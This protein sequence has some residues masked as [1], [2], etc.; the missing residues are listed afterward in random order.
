MKQNLLVA[1]IA[2]LLSVNVHAQGYIYVHQKTL[3]EQA[4][5]D[6]TYNLYLG[7]TA[8]GTPVSTFKL[9]SNPAYIN[10]GDIGASHSYTGTGGDGELWCIATGVEG[11]SPNNIS[12]TIYHRASGSSQWAALTAGT[13]ITA[14][15]AIDGAYTGQCVFVSG[16]NIYFYY[17]GATTR[18]YNGG[19]ATDVAAGGGNIVAVIN[20]KVR[21][22]PLAALA[23]TAV[24]APVLTDQ[25]FTNLNLNAT[26]CD[27]SKDGSTIVYANGG[28]AYTTPFTILTII[29]PVGT[30]VY[31]AA[32][33]Y[34]ASVPDVAYDDKGF[35]YVVSRMSANGDDAVYT[36]VSG[37][38]TLEP[39]SRRVVRVTGGA[40]GQAWGV[41]NYNIT[42]SKPNTI[43]SRVTDGSTVWFDDE[44][45]RTATVGTIYTHPNTSGQTSTHGETNGDAIMI[46]VTAGT[47]YTL[48]QTLPSSNWDLGRFV[49]YTPSGNTTTT[50]VSTQ[51]A[52]FTV[53]TGSI[54]HIEFIDELLSPKSIQLTCTQQSLETFGT[55]TATY[56]DTVQG[57]GYH[58]I[59]ESYAEDGD[60]FVVKN[61]STF[62]SN[63][64]L[65]SQENDGGY[66]LIV[67]ASYAQDEFYR[68]RVTNLQPGLNYTISFYAANVNP[69]QPLLPNIKYGLQDL[70]GN[71]INLASTGDIPIT[72][73]TWEQFSLTFTATQS[74]ADLF[75][76]NNNIGGSGNDVAIDEIALNPV[77][78]AL[79]DISVYPAIAPNICI[80]TSY[81]FSNTYSPGVWSTSNSAVATITP[82][83]GV[84][85]GLTTGTAVI[86][87]RYTSAQG[88]VSTKT[89]GV[90]VSAPPTG[91]TVTDK[92]G[93][94]ICR[95]QQDSLFAVPAGGTSPYTYV[96]G[97][98]PSVNDGLSTAD[99]TKQNPQISPT[100]GASATTY[101]YTVTVTDNV[102]CTVTGS[103]N[104]AVSPHDAPTVTAT[105]GGNVC[106][107][108][109]ISLFS[110]PSGGSGTYTYAWV[111]TAAGNGLGTTNT[112]NTSATPTASGTYLYTLTL[113]DGFCSIVSATSASAA[114]KPVISAISP[115]ATGALCVG[116]SLVL[117]PTIT[118]GASAAL[119]YSWAGAYK[120]G[121]DNGP[122]VQAPTTISAVTVIPVTTNSSSGNKDTYTYTLT[123]SDG[124]SCSAS[125]AYDLVVYKGSTSSSPT[126]S[127]TSPT[128]AAAV[129]SGSTISLTATAGNTSSPTYSWS[130]P[131]GYSSSSLSPGTITPTASGIYTITVTNSGGCKAF[132]A[133]PNITVNPV[134]TAT[135]TSFAQD[136]CIG[137]TTPTLD[138]LYGSATGG[139]GSSYTYAWSNTVKPSGAG[140]I[141]YTPK[142]TGDNDTVSVN[143]ITVAGSYTFQLTASD[144]TCSGT[145]TKTITAV[146]KNGPSITAMP[147][148]GTLCIST[149]STLSSTITVGDASISSYAWSALPSTGA[150]LG[151]VNTQNISVTPT[152]V[153]SYTYVL[154][155][156]DGDG[157]ADAGQSGLQVVNAAL[158]VVPINL[159]N[160]FC[161]SGTSSNATGTLDLTAVV[162]GGSGTYS[163]YAWTAVRNVS[164]GSVTLA[165][166]T[167]NSSP[168]TVA[169]L[170]GGTI[171]TTKYT[172]TLAVTDDAGCSASGSTGSVPVN[173]KPTVSGITV[174][175]ATTKCAGKAI[176]L[177]GTF[178]GGTSPY[179]YAWTSNSSSV[180]TNASGS[181]SSSPVTT[182]STTTS[183]VSGYYPYSFTLTDANGCQGSAT[184][185]I[186]FNPKPVPSVVPQ[187]CGTTSAGVNYVQLVETNGTSLSWAWTG[188]T[189]A[190]FYTDNT[191]NPATDG[192]TSTLSNPYVTLQGIYT[193]IVT[194]ANS[195]TGTTTYTITSATCGTIVL[196]VK[197]L[198]FT[199][200]KAGNKVVLNWSTAAEISS[201]YFAVERSGDG[202]KWETIGTVKSQVNSTAIQNYSYDDNAPLNGA[203][204]YRLRQVD[205]NGHFGYS[206]VRTVQF[207]AQ[208]LVHVYPNPASDFLVLEFNNDKEERASIS[209]QTTLGSTVFMKEQTIAKGYN[210]IVLNQ[211]QPLAQGAYIITLATKTNIHRS[212]FVKGD[213]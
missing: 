61:T 49:S 66:F 57:T 210:R 90:I 21:V 35:I 200:Q 136:I 114:A 70:N 126:V 133:T 53:A 76:S 107:G 129:C 153:G 71:L 33:N 205:L 176:N 68:K 146:A 58:Y 178:S 72:Q 9:N 11:T 118:A 121:P 175:A 173:G 103:K 141:T 138:S 152:A 93:G 46:P 144:G 81:T 135:A 10:A 148:A 47:T 198:S 60:Y 193:V 102:G 206:D 203:N 62:F 106:L 50:T 83:S 4:A 38:F 174:A 74:T 105:N 190:R 150:G 159:E 186:S 14:A 177:T 110:N 117:T 51:T 28:N 86:T 95:N 172:F 202:N 5:V 169:T 155:V 17:N 189:N 18:L 73:T 36:N 100:T 108:S 88:C 119:T 69:G 24:S 52:T 157:C 187:H 201:D 54:T 37:T 124:N 34:A 56:G 184:D 29:T 168:T 161:A 27:I 199:A 79:P 151:T 137:S 22:Y 171:G 85:Q 109:A 182:T 75:L 65:T 98:S 213:K 104:I 163:T 164:P 143:N 147:A 92:Y 154:K 40:A 43:W 32:T 80:G 25:T 96:W 91:V 142:T 87:Y 82:V 197:L 77:L 170:T 120:S 125:L 156:V 128:T 183:T 212:R 116:E 1:T 6:F 112:K 97:G 139:T 149:A 99:S 39:Q 7:S 162:S 207:T 166:A 127:I 13:G 20:G 195:C 78:L 160:G 45:V 123:V 208:W 132:D 31:T 181:V 191:I 122:G 63:T 2:L 180:V 145:T 179:S 194:D 101:K 140:T 131:G 113:N 67:N 48:V 204:F 89:T 196:P 16:G 167:S 64:G 41:I 165:P 211:I 44:R 111:G 94:S 42:G 8:S 26:R 15:T 209:V 130:G 84:V 185:S 134:P 158:A 192:T 115:S 30:A 23:Y 12:G 55:G 188:P 59:G 3:N 19:Q